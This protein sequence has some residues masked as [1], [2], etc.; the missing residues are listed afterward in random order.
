MPFSLIPSEL[1]VFLAVS[2]PFSKG[3][4]YPLAVV[5][6]Q[7]ADYYREQGEGRAITHTAGFRV[8]RE[9]IQRAIA[10]L[11]YAGGIR[12]CMASNGTSIW[13]AGRALRVLR[14]L[15]AALGG[16]AAAHC[17]VPYN[18]QLRVFRYGA[19]PAVLPCRLIEGYF[20][21]NWH[22]DQPIIDQLR[23]AAV[24]SGCEWCPLWQ[25][26]FEEYGPQPAS[27]YPCT[28]PPAEIPSPVR[29]L[30]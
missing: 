6:A 27:V 18:S 24:E 30:P 13:S 15:L 2:F 28:D 21:K 11:D 4:R 19:T 5:L 22:S 8:A 1:Q 10:L 3:D 7:K 16:G 14:C 9:S 23:A 20:I 17:R 25:P 26:V 12:G 29:L